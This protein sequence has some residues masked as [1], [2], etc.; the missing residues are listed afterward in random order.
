MADLSLAPSGSRSC[1]EPHVVLRHALLQVS[2]DR[3]AERLS[4]LAQM[5]LN[6]TL[7]FLPEHNLL[8]SDKAS[9]AAGVES[10]PP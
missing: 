6:D 7:V 8:Y 5:C 1:C 4:S 10:R 3:F 2:I 9:M